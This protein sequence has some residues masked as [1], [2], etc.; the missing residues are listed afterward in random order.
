M[1]QSRDRRQTLRPGL[2]KLRAPAAVRFLVALLAAFSAGECLHAD[3]G[4]VVSEKTIGGTKAVLFASPF[5]LRA[6]PAEIGA[7]LEDPATGRAILD[8][9]VS[10]RMNKLSAPTPEL[11]W[12]GPG[13][14]APGA[15]VP[16]PRGH[17]GNRLLHSAAIGIPE[18]GLWEIAVD[19]HRSGSV[20][21]F[22]FPVAVDPAASPLARYWPLLAMVPLG[23]AL[24]ALRNFLLRRARA[25]G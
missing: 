11:A 16:A 24:Y 18:P 13:C 10:F 12:K 20:T 14:I 15:K 7:Y 5:P 17:T 25:A 8:A 23:I 3:A 19:V 21:A 22:A 1:W 4:R 9:E 2:K 6:G